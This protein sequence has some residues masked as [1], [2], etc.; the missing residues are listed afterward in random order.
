MVYKEVQPTQLI[1]GEKYHFSIDGHFDEMTVIGIYQCSRIEW[2]GADYNQLFF[3]PIKGNTKKRS[4]EKESWVNQIFKKWWII[5]HTKIK[6]YLKIKRKNYKEKLRE[7]FE[8]TVLKIV[9]KK[10]VNEDFEWT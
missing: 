6:I 3:Y 1:K 5:D 2:D 10:I 4:K 8:Q 7:I 9:L